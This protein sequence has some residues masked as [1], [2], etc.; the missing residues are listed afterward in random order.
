MNEVDLKFGKVF[1]FV[2]SLGAASAGAVETAVRRDIPYYADAARTAAR[3]ASFA[4]FDARAKA[5]ERLTVVFFGGSLTWSANATD[6]NVTGFRGLMAKGLSE[7]YPAA[8]FTFV[9]ASIGGTGSNLG[10]FRLERDGLAKNPDL[11]VLDFACNDGGENAALPN[12][13][14]YEYLLR[15]MIGRGICVQQMFFTF[16]DWTKPGAVP[17]KVHPRRDVYRQLARAYGT[18]VGDVYE[19]ALWKRLNAGS[20]PIETVWPLDGGHPD[21][22]GYRMFADAGLAGFAQGVRDGAVCRVPEKPV[23]GTV[24]DVRRTNPAEGA[25]PAGWTRQ[26]TYRT[27]AWYDGL[28]SRWMGDV[29]AFSGTVRSPLTVTAPGN[30]VGLF[31]EGDNNSLAFTVSADGQPVFT[32]KASTGVGRLFIW[33]S[34]RL[35]D[36]ADGESRTHTFVIDPIPSADGKGELRIGSV[37]TATLVPV[38][39]DAHLSAPAASDATLEALDHAR[40]T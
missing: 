39:P 1:L 19:T 18:P 34:A 38:Q 16:R 20:V 36:W 28:S 31:G 11:V 17:S 12:T 5:G 3:E 29:A 8:H 4:A 10:L 9:D 13:C 21:D 22:I 24:R 32:G 7:R 35:D 2:L 30:F 37:C 14:C 40:G 6:P 26:L 33:R 27:S 15:E 25:L 23:F